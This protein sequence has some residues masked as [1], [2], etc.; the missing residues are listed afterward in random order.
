VWWLFSQDLFSRMGVLSPEECDARQHVLLSHYVGTVEIEVKCMVDM[1]NQHVIPA[2][3]AASQLDLNMDLTTSTTTSSTSGSGSGKSSQEVVA[4]LLQGV[5][6]LEQAWS[7][8]H[9]TE[10]LAVRAEMA[11]VL[12]LEAMEET[13]VLC[14]AAEAL[15]PAHLW[16]LSTY[17]DMLFID[18][19][20]D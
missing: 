9:H 13:R 6:R 19:T 7:D 2:L 17:K 8:I 10:D 11:R 12:R 16:T 14:D 18:Q 15:C 3:K 1:L 4:D 20:V 5:A